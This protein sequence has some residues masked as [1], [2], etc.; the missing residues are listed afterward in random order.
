MKFFDFDT[1]DRSLGRMIR[2]AAMLEFWLEQ[3]VKVLC[4]SPYGA[5]LISGETSS[6]VLKVCKVLIDAHVEVAEEHR[7]EF[8]TMLKE[9][10]AA[11]DRRH[12]YVH[13]AI[14]WE[15][16]GI[17]GNAR[18]RRLKSSQ[19]WQPI[20]IDDLNQ[21]GEELAR[22]AGRASHFCLLLSGNLPNQSVRAADS[23]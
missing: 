19:D 10:E 2:E 3:T 12:W 8:K 5:L 7:A 15:G 16:E 6:R 13:G 20:S 21:L 4:E 9:A 22:L 23:G 17:P 11:F 1:F 18:S 14:G